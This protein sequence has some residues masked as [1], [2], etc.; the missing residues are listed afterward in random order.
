VVVDLAI[1]G[2]A[3]L[4]AVVVHGLC[5]SAQVNDGQATV[6]QVHAVFGICPVAFGI[7]AAPRD[8][9]GHALEQLCISFSYKSGYSA[10]GG[11][12]FS[13]GKGLK[14]C[15]FFVPL[16]IFPTAQKVM[17]NLFQHL[18]ALWG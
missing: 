5:A 4:P 15:G 8:A 14:F 9:V 13:V 7:R 11:F 3:V 10:H 2:N 6:A 12:G 17:L 18:P 1:E 16:D